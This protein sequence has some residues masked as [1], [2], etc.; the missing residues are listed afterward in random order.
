MDQDTALPD[1]CFVLLDDNLSD[2]PA[3]LLFTGMERFVGLDAADATADTVAR[4]LADIDAGVADG[5]FAAGALAYEL[6]PHL[7][8][9]MTARPSPPP[10]VPVIAMGL[11]RNRQSLTEHEAAAFLAGLANDRTAGAS[12]ATAPIGD[13]ALDIDRD[14]YIRAVETLRDHIAAGR[15]YQVNY[16]FR[17]SFAVLCDPIALYQRLRYTQPVPYGAY[18]R[19]PGLDVLSRS[20]ELFFKTSGDRI[21]VKPMK[22]T[23][24]RGDS[25]ES[26]RAIADALKSDPKNR[27]ENVMIVDLMRNDLGRIAQPGTVTVDSLFDIEAYRSVNQMTSTVSARLSRPIRFSTILRALYPCGSV[28]GAPKIRTMEIIHDL[29]TS[30]RGIYTGAIG[31]IGPD[32]EMAFNVPIRTITIPSPTPSVAAPRTGYLGLGSGIVYDSDPAAEYEEC[33]LKGQYLF[34]L[35]GRG[36]GGESAGNE[37][38]GGETAP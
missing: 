28:T 29:E 12:P 34:A 21:T 16:T 22:G 4:A 13:I 18:L 35:S 37:D 36:H 33:L 1:S 3:S 7:D 8:Q 5:L 24:P 17:A 26:D 14:G 2:T 6:A 10:G 31:H 27:A 20:P 9:A 30:P 38:G 32:G 23:A 19:L 11:F 15:T 25:L